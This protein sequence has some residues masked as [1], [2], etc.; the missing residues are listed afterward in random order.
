MG[1]TVSY[2]LEHHG[3][4]INAVP[5]YERVTDRLLAL[6]EDLDVRGTFFVVGQLAERS[7]D[8]VRRVASAGH[9]IALHGFKHIAIGSLGER[10]FV[11]DIRRGKALLEDITGNPVDGYRAPLFSL[12]AATAWAPGQLLGEGIRYSSS[13]LP[14]PNP[15]NGL[16]GAPRSPFRWKEGLLELPCPVLGVGRLSVPYLGGVYLRYLPA[17]MLRRAAQRQPAEHVIW[18][19]VHPYDF[20]A[21]APFEVLPHAGWLTSRIVQM[22]RGSAFA[23]LRTVI[24]AGGTAPPL[25]ERTRALAERELPIFGE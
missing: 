7:P 25:G 13:V 11:E 22:R 20:D 10:G 3:R 12:T 6:L 23:R 1:V 15:I 2:D 8:L 18:T 16:P 24:E 5:A 9:E 4:P 17:P 14:A 19:Y 21:N